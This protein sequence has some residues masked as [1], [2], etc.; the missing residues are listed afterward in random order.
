MN[1]AQFQRMQQAVQDAVDDHRRKTEGIDPTHHQWS[2]G[3][4]F[5]GTEV[6]N[7]VVARKHGETRKVFTVP[8]TCGSTACI[9]GNGV[10]NNGD[11]MVIPKGVLD[12]FDFTT[13]ESFEV[14]EC[15]DLDGNLYPISKRA[16]KLFGLDSEEAEELFSGGNSI[17]AVEETAADL[18]EKYGHTLVIDHTKPLY[19]PTQQKVKA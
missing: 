11:R 6:G 13:Q 3:S 1:K 8:V 16:R 7:Q 19:N 18:A 12:D 10:I 17:E 5:Q 14:N 4:W 9:A 15:V 2:Q